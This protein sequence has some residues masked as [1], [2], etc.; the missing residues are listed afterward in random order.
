MR[1]GRSSPRVAGASRTP[2]HCRFDR[3]VTDPSIRCPP[4]AAPSPPCP[5]SRSYRFEDV[6]KGL[7]LQ[8]KSKKKLPDFDGCKATW[9]YLI[10]LVR[11]KITPQVPASARP[12]RPAP[13]SPAR[14][15]AAA[16]PPHTRMRTRT[17][18]T[19]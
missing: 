14:L 11:G 12:V 17:P 8:R 1:A 13:A 7:K 9:E 19:A 2:G 18:R 6:A 4:A 15:P 3:P 10:L 16:T 5:P